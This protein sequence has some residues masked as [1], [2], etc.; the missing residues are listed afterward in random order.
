VGSPV[1]QTHP[2]SNLP[3]AVAAQYLVPISSWVAA[4]CGH[5]GQ[6]PAA[7]STGMSRRSRASGRIT[8]LKWMVIIE[9]TGGPDVMSVSSP[10][11]ASRPTW[12]APETVPA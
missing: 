9:L 1:A 7:D 8:R 2:R 10:S 11:V 6:P 4:G 5:T 12:D 3:A